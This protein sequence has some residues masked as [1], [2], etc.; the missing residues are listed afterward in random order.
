MLSDAIRQMRDRFITAAADDRSDLRHHL[1]TRRPE[2]DAVREVGGLPFDRDERH[3]LAAEIAIFRGERGDAAHVISDRLGSVVID[4]H[5]DDDLLVGRQSRVLYLDECAAQVTGRGQP[6]LHLVSVHRGA[7]REHEQSSQCKRDGRDSAPVSHG[8]T[9]L[10]RSLHRFRRRVGR[11][12]DGGLE[13]R[14]EAAVATD[15]WPSWLASC[16]SVDWRA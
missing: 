3:V 10:H 15:Y 14:P 12:N 11:A 2:N 6:V 16:S 13:R 1:R 5:P 8:R 9:P 4:E 7:S